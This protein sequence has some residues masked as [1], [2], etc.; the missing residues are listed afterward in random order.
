MS[1]SR[2][3]G[4]TILAILA[5][6]GAIMACWC[7]HGSLPDA[8]VAGHLQDGY[9]VVERTYYQY[10][11]CLDVGSTCRN[12]SLACTDVVECGL[13]RLVIRGRSGDAESDFSCRVPYFRFRH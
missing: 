2:P 9:L 3:I 8:A 6:V 11:V 5:A 4:V 13:S 1:K 7:D 10:M 12:L